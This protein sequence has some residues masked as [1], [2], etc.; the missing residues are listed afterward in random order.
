MNIAVE[1]TPKTT[2]M[3]RSVKKTDEDLKQLEQEVADL[4]AANKGQAPAVEEEVEKEEPGLSKE[5][6]SWKKRY[7]DLRS[8][9][10]KQEK[11]LQ[12]QINDLKNQ[13]TSSNKAT[14]PKTKEEIENWIKKFPDVARIVKGIAR[15]EAS[16]E[17][18]GLETR[19]AE[20]EEMKNQTKVEKA[21]QQLL[22]S[23]PD[24]DEI[25]Q[26]DVFLDWLDVQPK[27]IQ[28]AL[29]EEL[30]VSGAVRAMDLYKLDKKIKP[31]SDKDAALTIGTRN[32]STPT[33]DSD[34]AAFSESQVQKMSW[35]EYEKNEQAIQ[36]AM[37][38]GKFKYDLS[39]AAR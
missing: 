5:E 11:A 36:E 1:T 6:A 33:E 28:D 2:F 19:M 17:A 31:K 26:S 21:K 32:R 13:I 14:L 15:E 30:D 27:W 29:Y 39:G 22:K 25:A 23:H 34:K 16:E 9:Q 37:R 10:T 20:F 18:R 3:S 24:F 12:D 7:S 8:H 38:T 35:R 4:E